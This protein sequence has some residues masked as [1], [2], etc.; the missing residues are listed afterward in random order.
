[1]P[2]H[3]PLVDISILHAAA[4]AGEDWRGLGRA[5]RRGEKETEGRTSERGRGEGGWWQRAGATAERCGEGPHGLGRANR[6]GE[7]QT[8]RRERER[9]ILSVRW[10]AV[11]TDTMLG[12]FLIWYR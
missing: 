3:P 12:I 9:T 6:R 1:M 2:I 8:K 7:R 11:G 5:S 10:L 4:A